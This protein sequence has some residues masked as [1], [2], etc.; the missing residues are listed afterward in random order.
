MNTTNL[1]ATGALDEFAE[2]KRSILNFG[3]PDLIHRSIDEVRIEEVGD[4]L[5]EALVNY[6][7]RLVR[8]T[9]RAER[10]KAVDGT[11]LKV[12]FVVRADL[13][14]DPLNLPVE[15][16]AEVERNTGQIS[17]SNR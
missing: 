2:V 7:P 9:I 17:I 3:M 8:G 15:F 14:C 5:I 13:N 11:D 10:D 12:R 6:E 16:V 4:E 1:D